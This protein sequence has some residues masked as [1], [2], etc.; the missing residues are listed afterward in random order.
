[1]ICTDLDHTNEDVKALVKVLIED[2]VTD[3]KNFQLVLNQ[4]LDAMALINTST[5]RP[6]EF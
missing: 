1:M 2:E 6:Y 3:G 5:A 4:I